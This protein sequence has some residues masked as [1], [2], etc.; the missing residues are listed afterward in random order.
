MASTHHDLHQLGFLLDWRE[1]IVG[2]C[3]RDHA[4]QVVH[5]S[6]NNASADSNISPKLAP[7]SDRRTR[8]VVE[9]PEPRQGPSCACLQDE[10]IYIFV[11]IELK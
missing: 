7:G 5:P 10:R 8:V 9:P 2:M 6:P 3:A 11:H 4:S 1:G